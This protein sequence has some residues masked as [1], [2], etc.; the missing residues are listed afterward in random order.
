MIWF[1][2]LTITLNCYQWVPSGRRPGW[3]RMRTTAN[4]GAQCV[5]RYH[6]TGKSYSLNLDAKSNEKTCPWVRIKEK[7]FKRLSHL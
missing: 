1:S 6:K 3:Q 7:I 2:F 5:E 4:S